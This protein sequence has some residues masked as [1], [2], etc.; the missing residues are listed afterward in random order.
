M[1]LQGAARNV[2]YIQLLLFTIVAVVGSRDFGDLA[3]LALG[4]NWDYMGGDLAILRGHADPLLAS[5]G[6]GFLP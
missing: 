1:D 2:E 6:R 4:V 5:G 3:P